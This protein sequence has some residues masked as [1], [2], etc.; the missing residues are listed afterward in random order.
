MDTLW[1]AHKIYLY[2]G[3]WDGFSFGWGHP[4]DEDTDPLPE[5]FEWNGYVYPRDVG[6]SLSS[7]GPFAML[8]IA[9]RFDGSVKVP[10][11]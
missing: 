10:K 6:A 8:E 1:K 5:S 7:D 2:D 11:E 9:Y 3:P 4:F